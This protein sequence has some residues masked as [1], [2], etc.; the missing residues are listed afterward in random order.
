MN[1]LDEFINKIQKK[2]PSLCKTK[3]LINAGL[4]RSEQSAAYARKM[5]F[6]PEFFQ[7]PSSEVLYPKESVIDY[8]KK[9]KNHRVWD[10]DSNSWKSST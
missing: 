1:A 9:A 10:A 4:Y 7:F 2:L 8:L 6:G 3:D 5:G